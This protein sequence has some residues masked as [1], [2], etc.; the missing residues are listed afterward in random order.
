MPNTKTSEVRR[1]HRKRKERQKKI[2]NEML[3]NAKKQT[4][5]D[6]HSLD[7]LPKQY[8]NRI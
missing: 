6:L 2:A 7:R 5:R 1:K 4:L 3:A 8:R